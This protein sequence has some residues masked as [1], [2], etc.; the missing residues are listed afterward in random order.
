MELCEF[1]LLW[2]H[3]MWLT[4]HLMLGFWYV[5]KV[6]F[7]LVIFMWKLGFKGGFI[8]GKRWGILW[9]LL[10]FWVFEVIGLL[11]NFYGLQFWV[12]FLCWLVLEL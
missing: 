12:A 2:L 8:A 11:R 5:C 6:D 3:F 10:C 9:E 4:L 7:M 1:C